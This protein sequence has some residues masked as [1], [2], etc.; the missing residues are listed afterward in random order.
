M[1]PADQDEHDRDLSAA[2]DGQAERFEKAPVQTDPAALA[3]LVAA[4]DLPP[5][6]ASWTPVP[7]RAWSPS[8][9]WRRAIG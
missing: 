2:F 3:R 5:D 6:R 9:S 4:A 8:P 7:G 1:K